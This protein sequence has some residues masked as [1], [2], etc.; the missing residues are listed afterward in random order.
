MHCIVRGVAKSQTRPSDFHFALFWASQVA[1][2]VKCLQSGRPRFDPWVGVIPWRRKW[3]PTPVPLPGKSHGWRSL[4][5]YSPWCHKGSDT[6]SDFTFLFDTILKKMRHKGTGTHHHGCT[7]V[8]LNLTYEI[9][10]TRYP[11]RYI[12]YTCAQG[13]A[14]IS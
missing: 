2:M 14:L 1:Q 4:V 13:A 11:I 12:I 6:R 3:H 8:S 7:S 9:P 5:C 10:Q